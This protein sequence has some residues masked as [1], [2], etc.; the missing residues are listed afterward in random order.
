[1]SAGKY[2]LKVEAIDN[3]GNTA[4]DEVTLSIAPAP[5]VI[6]LRAGWNLVGCPLTG[7]TP[8]D[9]AL[10]SIW[11]N[12][13]AVKNETVFYD[14][15]AGALSSL[16]VLEFGKGYYVNVAADCYLYWEQ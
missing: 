13:A 16:K 3:T 5:A 9:I 8:I 10:A 15:A 11:G 7:A 2:T 6:S 14:A 12:V 4:S 1:M